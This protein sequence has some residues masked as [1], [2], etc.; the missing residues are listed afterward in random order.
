MEHD[1]MTLPYELE[2][3]EQDDFVGMPWCKG[4]DIVLFLG[5]GFSADAGLPTMGEFGDKS[6]DELRALK[7]WES[8]ETGPRRA[9]RLLLEAGE[10]FKGF[11][12]FCSSG[13]KLVKLDC[14]N[15]ETLFCMAEILSEADDVGVIIDKDVYAPDYLLEQIR[16]WL[17]KMYTRYPKLNQSPYK[18]F[19][20]QVKPVSE[21]LSVL[22]TNY[23]ILFE[24]YAWDAE[25]RCMYPLIDYL[26]GKNRRPADPWDEF[27]TAV[28]RGGRPY[29]C[30][31]DPRG[32]VV[33]KL[34]GSVNYFE[35]EV[36]PGRMG[37][38]IS[39]D[40]VLRDEWIGGT[41]WPNPSS[42]SVFAL[43]SLWALRAKYG[44]SVVPAIVPPTYA[45][46]GRYE[47]LR[48]VWRNALYL[49]REARLI[50]FIGYSMPE[51]DGFMR[52]M[53]QTAMASRDTDPPKVC[54][55]DHSK[56]V[57]RR[58]K[59][60]FKPL[61]PVLREMSFSKAVTEGVIGKWLAAYKG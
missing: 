57:L 1:N 30:V 51:S 10:T 38:G 61:K 18:K 23:D 45:K 17:W 56:K 29:V 27:P 53:F 40:V 15:M 8:K 41:Q 24:Y 6:E 21:Q 3:R 54:V 34:H 32:P 35:R 59:E 19:M 22:S 9:V 58:Y 33:C 13:T 47:W 14:E 4:R 26:Q 50:V 7:A 44:S 55:V 52:A 25:L 16:L 2:F 42:P 46:L 49:L 43:G 36:E 48:A 20:E 28:Q 11:K 37:L 5:A 12:E 60:F 39:S 31:N